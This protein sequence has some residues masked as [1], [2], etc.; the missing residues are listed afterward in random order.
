MLTNYLKLVHIIFMDRLLNK[1]PDS[2]GN[3]P[4]NFKCFFF[5]K[6]SK[7]SND[8]EKQLNDLKDS[9]RELGKS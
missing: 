3:R 1:C 9:T 6:K 8:I 7:S 4:R 5:C 2:V